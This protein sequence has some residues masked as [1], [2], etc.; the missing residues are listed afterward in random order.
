MKMSGQKESLSQETIENKLRE[1]E[2]ELDSI[3]EKI[4][5]SYIKDEVSIE[6]LS[7]S[8]AQL[9]SMDQQECCIVAYQIQQYGMYIQSLINR[10]DNIKDWSERCLEILIGK[11]SK[12]YQKENTYVKFEEKRAYLIVENSAAEAL[13]KIFIKSAGKSKELYGLSHKISKMS[14]TLIELS[15]SKRVKNG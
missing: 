15:K 14:D 5:I 4:G 9:K 1:Y 13:N 7:L 8:Y 2:K 10:L 6:T 3:V 12:N 11:Y